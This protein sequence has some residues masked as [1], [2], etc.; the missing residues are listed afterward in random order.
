MPEEQPSRLQETVA[1][2]VTIPFYIVIGIIASIKAA[3]GIYTSKAMEDIVMLG[4]ISG[5]LYTV[6]FYT[7]EV[8]HVVEATPSFAATVI[9]D[10]MPELAYVLAGAAVF[11]VI[12]MFVAA[13]HGLVKPEDND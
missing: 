6:I 5:I 1:L 4:F 9:S 8:V 3:H 7:G 13:R 11:A 2:L 12:G 10:L